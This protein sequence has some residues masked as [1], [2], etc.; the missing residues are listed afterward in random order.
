MYLG[1]GAV[2]GTALAS[3]QSMTSAMR[4][5][6]L[7]VNPAGPLR[8][9]ELA[10][11]RDVGVHAW[12]AP[13]SAEH[14]VRLDATAWLAPSAAL[15]TFDH[16]VHELEDTTSAS[17]TITL[18]LSGTGPALAQAAPA[19]ALRYQR[20]WPR[21]NALS[22]GHA[23]A[24]VLAAHRELHD[25]RLPLVRADHEHALDVWQWV[26]RLA[27]D[28]SFALQVA[29]LFH[30]IERLSTEARARVE[31]H[32][33]DYLAFKLA[34]ADRGSVLTCRA[35]LGLCDPPVL[36]RVRE[37]VARHEQPDQ[38][39]DLQTLND[40]D[41]L[42]FFSLNSAGFL[43]YFGEPHTEHKVRYT[44]LRMRS[45]AARSWLR[46]LRVEPFIERALQAALSEPPPPSLRPRPQPAP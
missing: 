38:D 29:A 8:E 18:C 15:L 25:C 36:A 3:W 7:R 33:P 34:H 35:L 21:T 12:G 2:R 11:L 44:L 31:Q 45:T 19:V 26:L 20:L 9:A 27:P 16:Q 40:A 39:L 43:A 46:R 13:A 28:A 42:S 10:L 23:F 30:D 6:Q 41:A 22:G 17:D 4:L 5:G 37:L 24:R 32:A 1:L 14:C